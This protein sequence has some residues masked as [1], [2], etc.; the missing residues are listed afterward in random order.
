MH[1]PNAS[2]IAKRPRSVG[3]AGTGTGKASQTGQY[4]LKR[5]FWSANGPESAKESQARLSTL[6]P[7][8]GWA[9]FRDAAGQAVYWN[10]TA[11][12]GSDAGLCLFPISTLRPVNDAM[13]AQ[14]GMSGPEFIGAAP[15]IFSPRS[16]V[17]QGYL[18]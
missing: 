1:E 11:D 9:L 2:D 4:R 5:R 3:N 8:V 17:W 7:I 16:G 10:D 14:Y 13:L 15:E 12:K 6:Q 18:A